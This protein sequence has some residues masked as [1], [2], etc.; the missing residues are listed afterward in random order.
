[1]GRIYCYEYTV[2]CIFKIKFLIRTGSSEPA[3]GR[4]QTTEK[5]PG[6]IDCKVSLLAGLAFNNDNKKKKD[7]QPLKLKVL[8]Q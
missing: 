3:V 5:E 2:E 6:A 4:S 8:F 7:N 1:M